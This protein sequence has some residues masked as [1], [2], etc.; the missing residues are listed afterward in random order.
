MQ[1]LSLNGAWQV[2]QCGKA[3]TYAARVPGCVHEDLLRAGAIGDPYFRDNEIKEQWIGEAAWEYTRTFDVPAT[4]LACARVLLEC[5]GLDTFATITL[6]GRRIARTDN[7]FRTW[8]FDVRHALRAGRNTITVRFASVLP[9]LRKRQAERRLNCVKSVPH[10]PAGRGYVRK[11]QCNFG[12]DWGP[13]LVTCGIFRALRIVAYDVARSADVLVQQEHVR[14]A[15]TLDVRTTVTRVRRTAGMQA[16]VC[17]QQG[18]RLVAEICVPVARGAAHARLRIAD[19]ALWWPR[20]LGA[21]PLYTVTVTLHDAAG[22][23][24]D[25]W[26]R[27]IGLRTLAVRRIKDQWGESFAFAANGV[28]FFAKGANWIPADAIYTRVT[29]ARYRTL[30]HSA[31]DANMNMLRVWGGGYYEDDAL[32]ELC[33]ELGLCVWQDCMFACCV[34]PAFD[35]QFMASVLAEIADNVQRLR[36]HACLALW[37]GNNELEWGAVNDADW[38]AFPAAAYRKMFD[39]DIAKVVRAHDPQ[40]QYWPS[41]PHTPGKNRR[42]TNDPSRGDA[43]LWDVWHGRQPFE[44]F[45]T[46]THRFVSECGFQSF[47]APATVATFTAPGDRAVNS[48]I[49]DLHQRS[50]IGNAVIMHYMLDWF[51]MPLGFAN[52]IWLSQIQQGLAIKYAVEHWR[53][54]VPRCMGAL[55]W[56]LN[57]CWP[58]VS[59]ASIDFFGR[60]KALHYLARRF[61]APVL[62]SGVEHA[63]DGT[64]AVH[65]SNDQRSELRATLAWRV[66]SVAGAT[67]DEGRMPVTTPAGAA[68]Q[69]TILKLKQLVDKHGSD[70]LL[71]W[72]CVRKGPTVLAENLVHFERPRH[73]RLCDPRL[74]VAAQ[75]VG[76]QTFD[77]TLGARRPALWVW[78]DFG[79][80]AAQCS[81][82]Y[83]CMPPHER[84]CVRVTVAAP[85]G[86]AEFRPRLHVRSIWDTFAHAPVR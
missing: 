66:T 76:P 29:R 3:T 86:L 59:W 19:P 74:A 27:K 85:L 78:L 73:L 70:A 77:V 52:A 12:W 15:V 22:A 7:M 34:Y 64:V 40:R 10:E 49:M 26:S 33:D 68:R 48:R 4:L 54:L 14:G 79:D 50:N 42:Q 84:V 2:R 30:L 21:Q 44:W 11:M 39:K 35:A 23:A 63:A 71:V 37:C 58:V 55:Y 51:A 28:P 25:A 17:V 16:R 38:P 83:F 6:N 65:V 1:S 8:R 53:R 75:Q 24:L 13:V 57:D 62:V 56:Q 81:D 69:A 43:H 20:G 67:L 60:W 5:D 61:Y 46:S 80:L 36:H 82:N 31:A 41:S 18:R 32:Y 45:R 47:P 72:L 9:Y